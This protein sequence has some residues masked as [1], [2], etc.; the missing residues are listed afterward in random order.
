MAASLARGTCLKQVNCSPA[1]RA[2]P[3]GAGS[4]NEAAERERM[5]TDRY[6]PPGLRGAPR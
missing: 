2:R 4:T 5:A 3:E 6:I 1:L